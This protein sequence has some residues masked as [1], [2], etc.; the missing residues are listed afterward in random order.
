MNIIRK[1][2][3]AIIILLLILVS[4]L[5]YYNNKSNITR[6]PLFT[7]ANIDYYD[8]KYHDGIDVPTGKPIK[9]SYIYQYDN[10]NCHLYFISTNNP[11]HNKNVVYLVVSDYYLG[12]KMDDKIYIYNISENV[13][14][15]VNDIS[16]N[17][18]YYV[19]IENRLLIYN[20]IL[21]VNELFG[22]RL[23]QDCIN[24]FD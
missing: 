15:Y 6:K 17:V 11:A 5:I 22:Q 23:E 16:H 10:L 14:Y 8:G 18:K 13:K 7:H 2:L 12:T 21:I 20:N 24:K 19:K 3:I 4:L 1:Y 9:Y